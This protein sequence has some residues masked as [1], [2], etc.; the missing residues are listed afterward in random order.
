MYTKHVSGEMTSEGVQNCVICGET[1]TDY[2]GSMVPKGSPPLRGFKC[3]ELIYIKEGN[4]KI[5][6]TQTPLE[7]ITDCKMR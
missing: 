1:L 5:T 6:T 3:G 2:R 7:S 4:P